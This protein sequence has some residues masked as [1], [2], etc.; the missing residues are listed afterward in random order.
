MIRRP[1]RSTLSSSSAAS[2]VYKRQTF[3]AN[4]PGK[5]FTSLLSLGY[6]LMTDSVLC[7]PW[8]EITVTPTTIGNSSNTAAA[9]HPH[10]PVLSTVVGTGDQALLWSP[11]ITT[12]HAQTA[13]SASSTSNAAATPTTAPLA[14]PHSQDSTPSNSLNIIAAFGEVHQSIT[15]K[16]A[17]L[18]SL[19]HILRCRRRG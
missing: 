4:A 18:L 17:C 7:S 10:P 12:T 13:A 16:P 3:G 19:I 8:I 2:D 9:S 15:S 1:P 14:S 6:P 5:R 11:S